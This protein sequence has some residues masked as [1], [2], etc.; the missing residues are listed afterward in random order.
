MLYTKQNSGLVKKHTERWGM[1]AKNQEPK[2]K[3]CGEKI[4]LGL[5][6]RV[7]SW[8]IVAKIQPKRLFTENL[9]LYCTKRMQKTKLAFRLFENTVFAGR[10][11][12]AQTPWT[13]RWGAAS[14]F[15]GPVYIKNESSYKEWK[16]VW[17]LQRCVDKHSTTKIVV[18]ECK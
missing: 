4:D 3:V 8:K 17:L 9:D 16:Q 18:S 13:S 6:I 1:S 15:A 11:G 5:G 10:L 12:H 2:N 7:G 14:G